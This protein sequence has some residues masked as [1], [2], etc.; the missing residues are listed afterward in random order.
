MSWSDSTDL[1]EPAEVEDH[2]GHRQRHHATQHIVPGRRKKAAAQCQAHDRS[3][4]SA[5]N[6]QYCV[7]YDHA[8][9]PLGVALVALQ[10]AMSNYMRLIGSTDCK[11]R[12]YYRGALPIVSLL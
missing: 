1:V 3:Y 8:R 4:Q 5:T 6:R 10:E 7:N 11:L 2:H 12:A 9:I